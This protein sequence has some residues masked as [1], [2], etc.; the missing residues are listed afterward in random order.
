MCDAASAALCRRVCSC[1]KKL[2]C[3]AAPAALFG[4]CLQLGQAAL[5][6]LQVAQLVALEHL[7]GC[8]LPGKIK[9]TASALQALYNE[10]IVVEVLFPARCTSP[11]WWKH[12][13]TPLHDAAPAGSPAGRSQAWCLV[14][15]WDHEAVNR[16][17]LYQRRGFCMAIFTPDTHCQASA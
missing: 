13:G 16:R 10:E 6:C 14:H 8:V 15:H 11:H 9:Q 17:L 5:E 2:M 4:R 3:D 1:R 7:V 12:F